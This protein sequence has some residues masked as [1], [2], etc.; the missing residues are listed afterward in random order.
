MKRFSFAVLL[1]GA[2]LYSC[3]ST[4]GMRVQVQR[5][6]AITV[7][8][9]IRTVALLNHSIPAPGNTVESVLTGEKPVQDK[10]LSEECLRG[11]N[12]LLQ[13]SNRFTVR[14]C[15]GTFPAGDPKSLSF[16]PLMSWQTADSLCKAYNSQALLVLEY[17]DTDFRIVNPAATA[18]GAVDAL[19]NTGTVE[20]TITGQ[21]ASKAGFRIYYPENQTI[22]YQ[23]HFD[24]DMEWKQSSTNPVEAVSRLIRR[25]EALMNVSY[26]N[27]EQFAMSIVPLYYWE[28]RVLYKG[29][30]GNM[31]RGERQALAKD[32]EGAVA[33][34]KDVYESSAKAKDRAKAA[35]NIGL[36][37]EVLGNLDEARAWV[38]KAYVEGGKDEALR[39]SDILDARI[40]EQARL[41][42]QQNNGQ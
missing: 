12:D 16:G 33:T 32:W 5:P 3:S 36:G 24:W 21:A 27:G 2:F 38:Q 6:A 1:F 29:K 13:T 19:L 37:M 4:R 10:E 17:F 30:K 41:Q 14:R 26:V 7:Q 23:D 35:F 28:D 20:V 18:A 25:N 15:E 39:Y 9:Q 22:V 8:Q 42:E 31:E 34:W 11:L 40:R